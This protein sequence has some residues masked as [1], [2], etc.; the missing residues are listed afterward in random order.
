MTNEGLP[1]NDNLGP[2]LLGTVWSFWG[3][4][5]IIYIIRLCTRPSGRFD[6]T[7]AEYTITAA[8]IS[9]TVSVGFM[10]AAISKGFGRHNAYVSKENQ[11]T[12]RRYLVGV[13]MS[14]CLPLALR[15][16]ILKA[17]I[18]LQVLVILVYEVSQ[19]VQCNSVI[20]GVA[21]A[22]RK[23]LPKDQVWGFTFMSFSTAM[24]S[25]FICATIPIFLFRHLSR[26][27]VEKAL[28]YVLMASSIIATGMGI[29]KLYHVLTYEY[30]AEDWLWNLLPEFFWCRMEE[31]AIIIAACAPCSRSLL[32]GSCDAWACQPSRS[33]LGDSNLYDHSLNL[34]GLGID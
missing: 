26:S 30:G 23:C 2:A 31:A 24:L 9:K 4:A 7:A 32:K 1:P 5:T 3:I 29:P 21:P 8:L 28:I 11:G 19:F 17:T 6:I 18:I 22:D 20:T 14:G 33:L 25:D 34:Q 13:F 27:R 10:T 15:E 16:G 12:I